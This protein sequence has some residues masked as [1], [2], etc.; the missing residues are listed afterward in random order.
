MGSNKLHNNVT[1]QNERECNLLYS[2][3]RTKRLHRSTRFIS[4]GWV[5]NFISWSTSWSI[6]CLHATQCKG[7]NGPIINLMVTIVVK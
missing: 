1:H 4:F 2:K 5:A 3:P 6:D 7:C